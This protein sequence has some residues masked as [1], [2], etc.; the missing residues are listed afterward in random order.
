M[1]KMVIFTL[2]VFYHNYKKKKKIFKV[3]LLEN[4]RASKIL[5]RSE[6]DLRESKK[7]KKKEWK[8][9]YFNQ[10]ESDSLNFALL[11]LENWVDGCG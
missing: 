8:E 4:R 2:C 3:P 1:V 5:S 7:K 9:W 11:L 6:V 10:E